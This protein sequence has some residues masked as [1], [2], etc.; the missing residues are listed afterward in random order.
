[1]TLLDKRLAPVVTHTNGTAYVTEAQAPLE[2]TRLGRWLP[3]PGSLAGKLAARVPLL[4]FRMGLG[5][6]LMA[7][8]LMVLTTR[9]RR[10]GK[11]RRAML[12]FRR[13]GRKVYVV[14]AWGQQSHWVHNAAAQA[15]V[16]VQMGGR[17][18]HALATPVTDRAE[19]AR[20]LN[21][22]RQAAPARYDNVMERMIARPVNGRNLREVSQ[23]FTIYRLDLTDQ[24][25]VMPPLPVNLRWLWLAG[26]AAL[27]LLVIGIVASGRK[28]TGRGA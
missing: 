19:A 11:L 23:D 22:F 15:D 3:Y 20:A 25:P 6:L 21:L 28:S 1:M 2:G 10:T 24:E 13:H 7:L 27:V 14:S 18:Q 4:L 8:R 12:E 26:L 17:T 5:D 16:T 9:G